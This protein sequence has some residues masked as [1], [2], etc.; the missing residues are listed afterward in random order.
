METGYRLDGAQTMNILHVIASVKP[1]DGGP[2][3]CAP[4]LAASQARLGH[5]VT[6]AYHG[7]NGEGSDLDWARYSIPHIDLVEW[8]DVPRGR[9]LARLTAAAA[10]QGLAQ[11][12][13]AA[14]VVHL[15]GVWDPLVLR[16]ASLAFRSNTN[17]VITPHGMLNPWSLSQKPLR[18]K[19]VMWALVRRLLDGATFIHALTRDEEDAIRALNSSYSVC[20]IPNGVFLDAHKSAGT[21]E[22]LDHVPQLKGRN[23]ILFLGR[24][25]HMKGLDYAV[26]G[27]ARFARTVRDVDWVVAGPDAGEKQRLLESVQELGIA[28]RVHVVGPLLGS[29]K[30]AALRNASCLLQPSRNEGFSMSILEAL[31]AGVPVVISQHCHFDEVADAEVGAVVPLDAQAI[32]EALVTVC[33]MP[34]GRIKTARKA[35]QM[36]AERYNWGRIATAML[37]EYGHETDSAQDRVAVRAF[38]AKRGVMSSGS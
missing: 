36:L 29:L 35:R 13:G 22:L 10:T 34:E 14:D 38:S 27:F 28:D 1:R 21:T 17:Y 3:V 12:I 37:N 8:V 25:H 15:H 9:G 2:S 4:S 32:S 30:D 23:Y 6:L 5:E 7:E 33:T 19:V 24:L 20:V 16:V 18:K 31:A 11:Y 26:Q